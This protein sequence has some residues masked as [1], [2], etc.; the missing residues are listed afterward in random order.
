[1][2]CLLCATFVEGCDVSDGSDG[3]DGCESWHRIE[4]ILWCILRSKPQSMVK[5]M[6][7]FC[8]ALM[9]CFNFSSKVHSIINL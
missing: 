8:F 4:A 2:V 7:C 6:L 9:F 5:S 1:M 3:C